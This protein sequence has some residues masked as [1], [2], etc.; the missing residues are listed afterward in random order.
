MGMRIEDPMLGP[1]AGAKC[2]GGRNWRSAEE[3]GL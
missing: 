2:G 3:V 1:L